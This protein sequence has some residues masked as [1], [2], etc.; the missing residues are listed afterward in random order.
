[1]AVH[2]QNDQSHRLK[3]TPLKQAVLRLLRAEGRARAEV[4]VLLTDDGVVQAMNRDYRGKDKPTDVLS[5]AQ[6]EQVAGSPV[7][8]V[9]PGMP[10]ILGDVVISVDTA[11][12]QAQQHAISLDQELALL[13]VHGVLHLIGYEDETEAGAE[14]MRVREREILGVALLP[15]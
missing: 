10:V 12:R 5:F 7:P 6:S 13:A 4:S 11:I 9:I 8:P 3:T 1:M 2:L 14:Q 15:V